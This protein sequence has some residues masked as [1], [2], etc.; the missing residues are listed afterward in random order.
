MVR[1]IFI[2]SYTLAVLCPTRI[3]ARVHH[4]Y[5]LYDSSE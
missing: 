2:Y 1:D 3:Y 4:L 5:F